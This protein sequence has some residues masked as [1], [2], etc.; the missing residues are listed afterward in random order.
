M[1]E[2]KAKLKGVIN[3]YKYLI[4]KSNSHKLDKAIKDEIE[5]MKKYEQMQIEIIEKLKTKNK[6]F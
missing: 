5:V 6:N 1:G 2:V 4:D 3:T